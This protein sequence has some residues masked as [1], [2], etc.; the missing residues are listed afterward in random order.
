MSHP[1]LSEGKSVYSWLELPYWKTCEKSA[2]CFCLWTWKRDRNE[3]SRERFKPHL[4]S[5]LSTPRQS[6]HKVG[7]FVGLLVLDRY[8]NCPITP[9]KSYVGK[10]S[11]A[12]RQSNKYFVWNILTPTDCGNFHQD[13]LISQQ[14][15]TD[16]IRIIWKD[17]KI[18][19]KFYT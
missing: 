8:Q 5:H 13:R 4:L 1:I 17:V 16:A 2:V 3:S 12:A 19:Y 14:T 9:P 7:L 18:T 10:V 11:D 15:K 6:L